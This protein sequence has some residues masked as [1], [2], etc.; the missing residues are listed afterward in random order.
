MKKGPDY[1]VGSIEMT[2]NSSVPSSTFEPGIKSREGQAF[3][4]AKLEADLAT[5]EGAYRLR[6]FA[7]A[8]AQSAIETDRADATSVLL[9]I[10]ISVSEGPQTL[11]G[12]VVLQGNSSVS[13]TELQQGL[14]LQ[15]GRPY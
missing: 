12:S 2:G 5:I 10:R 13:Q 9:S 8:K 15:P 11:V 6:G 7:S 14:G 3:S 1:R 4:D